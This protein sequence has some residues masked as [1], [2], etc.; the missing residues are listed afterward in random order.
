[1][2]RMF[3]TGKERPTLTFAN[4]KD[5]AAC[6]TVI[7]LFVRTQVSWEALMK[8]TAISMNL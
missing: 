4:N 6:R 2:K 1:M 5:R 7:C 3:N 8:M